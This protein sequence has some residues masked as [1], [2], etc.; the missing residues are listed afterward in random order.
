[1]SD[2]AIGLLVLAAIFGGIRTSLYFG[3]QWIDKHLT[4]KMPE[5]DKSKPIVRRLAE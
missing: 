3:E 5:L 1:M 2:W 4:L